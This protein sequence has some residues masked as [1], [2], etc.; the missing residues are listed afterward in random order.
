MSGEWLERA[1]I[2]GV[3]DEGA[4]VRAAGVITSPGVA[5]LTRSLPADAGVMISASHSPY[6]DNGIK[7]FSP[8]GRKLDGSVER[9]IEADIFAMVAGQG[10]ASTIDLIAASQI[11]SSEAKQ[12]H[13]LYLDFLATEIAQEVSL[14]KLKLVVDCA[15]GSASSFAPAL[16]SRLGAQVVAINNR[17]DGYNIN[18]ESGSLHIEGLQK[19]VLEVRADLGMA[20][21]GD[22]DRVLFVDA[23]GNLIDGDATLWVL[24]KYL[25]D[26]DELR[27]GIV[28]ATVMSNIGLEI[29]LRSRG[30]RLIRTDVGDKNILDELLRAGANLGGE[31]SGHIIIP[32]E[33]LAGDGIITAI[34][35]LS[36]MV[37]SSLPFHVLTEG[38]TRYPQVLTN[39][40]VR[41]KIPFD[42]VEEI[43]RQVRDAE[44]AL[45]DEG[46]LLLRYSGTESLARILVEGSTQSEIER[47]A[48]KLATVIKR[49]LEELRRNRDIRTFIKEARQVLK[50]G[51]PTKASHE[52]PKRYEN[53]IYQTL[54][55]LATEHLRSYFAEKLGGSVNEA[56]ILLSYS[57][58]L[59]RPNR[60]ITDS[61]DRLSG[62][63]D[64]CSHITKV[65]DDKWNLI[66][67][68]PNRFEIHQLAQ[69]PVC[70]KDGVPVRVPIYISAVDIPWSDDF[71]VRP[72]FV[73]GK[74]N[75]R[76]PVAAYFYCP[77]SETDPSEATVLLE[78]FV[79]SHARAQFDP[80][81]TYP[82]GHLPLEEY[83]LYLDYLRDLLY[84]VRG[85]NSTPLCL[86]TIAISDELSDV[87]LGTAMIFSDVAILPEMTTDI[88]DLCFDVFGAFYKIESESYS[89]QQ[90]AL[91]LANWINHEAKNWAAGIRNRA[92][93]LEKQY[94]EGGPAEVF[95]IGERLKA[96]AVTIPLTTELLRQLDLHADAMPLNDFRDNVKHILRAVINKGSANNFDCSLDSSLRVP[97]GLLVIC[98][99]LI[100]NVQKHSIAV[101]RAD[102]KVK[103]EL[104]KDNGNLVLIV[105]SS[106]HNAAT[107]IPNLES[108]N[109][110]HSLALE[111]GNNKLGGS[112]IKSLVSI[113]GGRVEWRWEPKTAPDNQIAV[114][115]TCIVPSGETEGKQ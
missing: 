108:L 74:N 22:A 60:R 10:L 73:Y 56:V 69:S 12:M 11:E 19:E 54:H 104:E 112:L 27:D 77:F 35:V 37:E 26:R 18:R 9:L 33:S 83:T 102:V 17:P 53:T 88:R 20:F 79:E 7:I 115:V 63:D 70:P 105:S 43:A 21:D 49:E 45:G 68:R 40:R 5:Y 91:L 3:I 82:A 51:L 47:L 109:S 90:T 15:N 46:R 38:F 14:S 101:P 59:K 84:L 72:P 16:F 34:N 67:K 113:M 71:V 107:S 80:E 42:Q 103:V 50:E 28:V 93:E 4:Q 86:C 66:S 44:A 96:L 81:E 30:L 106:P 55:H 87:P 75:E 48:T 62:A 23:N 1:L 58:L 25:A 31:Q 114:R 111:D 76:D 29:A 39:I 36:A 2:S 57:S 61:P 98:M 89:R 99:E 32:S 65:I 110:A 13:S 6:Q 24:A 8:S 97:R 92:K 94:N 41:D 52:L 64:L 95:E 85:S 78:Q 100:R